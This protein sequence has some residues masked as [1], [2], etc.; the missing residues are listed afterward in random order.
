MLNGITPIDAHNSW[1]YY[2]FCRN[3]GLE[4]HDATADLVEGLRVVLEEDA[5]ALRLQEI[6]MQQ[7]PAGERDVLI[8]QDAGLAKARKISARLL[9]AEVA[10][11]ESRPAPAAVP[12]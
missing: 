7:R 12:S 9:A 11:R 1:Y 8:A 4:S 5:Q 2:A 10:E 3:F 6:G